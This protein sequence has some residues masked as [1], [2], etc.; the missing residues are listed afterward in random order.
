MM[1]MEVHLINIEP[2]LSSGFS[3]ARGT[4]FGRY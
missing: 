1:V 2:A 4:C 3:L